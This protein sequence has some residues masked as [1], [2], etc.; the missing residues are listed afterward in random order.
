MEHE[1]IVF[2]YEDGT[3]TG[4]VGPKLASHTGD[5]KLHLAFSCYVFRRNDNKFLL[6][7]RATSKKVWPGV[8][9]N[10]VCGHPMPAEKIEDAI[11]RR[12]KDE[13]GLQ[14]LD[15]IRCILPSY[16]YTTPPYNGIIEN[17]FCPVFVA[18]TSEDITANPGEV[19]AYEW[20]EWA[21]YVK[22][23]HNHPERMSYWAKDQYLQLKDAQPFASLVDP[24]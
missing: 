21:D 3:P 18:Y 23:L 1:Q 24:L 20:L 9:T 5:T 2:V 6:T 15:G 14:R 11:R 8:W 19:G 12:A 17:E 22:L 7:Q 13:L 10:S 16:R 4:E